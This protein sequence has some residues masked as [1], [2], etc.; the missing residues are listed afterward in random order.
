[1]H[2]R[3]KVYP[4]GAQL[5]KTDRLPRGRGG[6]NSANIFAA[7]CPR[8]QRVCKFAN[9]SVRTARIFLPSTFSSTA[10]GGR[11]SEPWT[12]LPRTQA[13][14]PGRLVVLSGSK[15]VRLQ[16]LPTMGCFG[17]RKP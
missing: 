17:S 11:R 3:K 4:V 8:V 1:M 7:L 15:T 9:Y 12:M 16:G 14:L 6:S 2:D 5:V 10:R 13:P